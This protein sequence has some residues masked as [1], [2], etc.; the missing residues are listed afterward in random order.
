LRCMLLME[1]NCRL[2]AGGGL[3]DNSDETREW[4]ETEYKLNTMLDVLR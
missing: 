2:Y 1:L 4:R 3:L